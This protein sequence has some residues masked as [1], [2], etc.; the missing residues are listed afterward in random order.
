MF[1]GDSDGEG[2]SLVIYFKVSD[3][4]ESETPQRYLD[5][6]KVLKPFTF[7]L[8]IFYLSHSYHFLDLFVE[9]HCKRDGDREEFC[10]GNGCSVQ[11]EAKNH[12]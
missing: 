12:G 10:K 9:I 4:F 7:I 2:M 3:N 5:T 1:L 6:L 8:Y 11:R